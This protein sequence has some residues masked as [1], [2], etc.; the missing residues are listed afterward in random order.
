MFA[1]LC[2]MNSRALT[3]SLDSTWSVYV[4]AMLISVFLSCWLSLHENIINPDGICYLQ[5]AAD[6]SVAGLKAASQLCDQAKWPFYS[7]L[8]H[9]VAHGTHLTY[10]ASAYLLDGA[11]SIASVLSFIYLVR[12][13]GGTLRTLWLAAFVILFAHEFD[14]IREYIV[15]DHGFWAFYLIAMI[16]LIE[17][18]RQ[19]RILVALLWSASMVTA[20]LFR[21]E[22]ALFL[23]FVPFAAWSDTRRSWTQRAREFTQLNLFLLMIVSGLVVMTVLSH[24]QTA[25]PLGRVSELEAQL[26]FGLTTLSQHFHGA[27]AALAQ[28]VLNPNAA[29]DAGVVLFL[30]LIIWYCYSLVANISFIYAFLAVYA[31][32]RNLLRLDKSAQ[33]VLFSYIFINVVVTSI[34]LAENIFISK[35]YLIALSLVFMLWVPFALDKLLQEKK[36]RVVLCAAV[37]VLLFLNAAGTLFHFGYS[38]DYILQAGNWLDQNVPRQASLYSND[39]LVMYYSNHFGNEIFQ[40]AR[41]DADLA[42]IAAGQW[43]HYDYLA[44]RINKPQTQTISLLKELNSQPLRV[45]ANRRGDE[46]VIYKI[47]H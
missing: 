27:A 16:F 44:L 40:A 9:S 28:H 42:A 18:F 6:I 39:E 19:P 24:Q 29:Q 22:G 35:R 30:L 1:R 13:L 34:Y 37:A 23:L 46:V 33:I 4:I 31:W 20:T 3:R 36:Q 10:L 45:F 7:V 17:Y 21:I 8:I 26:L 11:L 41:A 38:K 14:S 25:V 15:R 32:S 43:K 2:L 5:S 12:L 47:V